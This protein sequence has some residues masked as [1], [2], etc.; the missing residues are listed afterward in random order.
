MS[1]KC[2]KCGGKVCFDIDE[3]NLIDFSCLSCGKRW[4][5]EE[6]EPKLK[7]LE[8]QLSGQV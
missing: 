5:Y 3:G 7:R 6:G 1:I 2:G 4:T 8:R